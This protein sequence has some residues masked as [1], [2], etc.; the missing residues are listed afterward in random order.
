MLR[1]KSSQRT[2]NPIQ[3]LI[4]I[5]IQLTLFGGLALS[6][7][8]HTMTIFIVAAIASAAVVVWGAL[9]SP[10]RWS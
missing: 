3:T 8:F 4:A 7:I 1:N 5:G 9:A 2:I 6:G 10:E